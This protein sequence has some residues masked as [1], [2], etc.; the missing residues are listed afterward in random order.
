MKPVAFTLLLAAALAAGCN[1]QDPTKLPGN[2]AISNGPG[3]GTVGTGVVDPNATVNGGPGG[4][5]SVSPGDT[6]LTHR[7]ANGNEQRGVL[8]TVYFGFDKF[9]IESAERAKL[10]QAAAHLK[11]NA[12]DRLLVEGSCDWRGTAEYNLGLGDRRANAVKQYLV[13]IGVEESRVDTKSLGDSK[14]AENGSEAQMKED[15]RAELVVVKP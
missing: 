11:A 2:G 9:A 8:P 12:K 14:A 7:G 10:D 3:A 6:D 13:Q 4:N 5:G 1:S 15:R